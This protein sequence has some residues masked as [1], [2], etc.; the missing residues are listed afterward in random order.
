MRSTVLCLT[1]LVSL[2]GCE[3]SIDTLIGTPGGGGLTA[4]Q[5]SGNWSFTLTQAGPLSC[6]SG[7]L[8]NGQVLTARLDVL[9]DGTLAAT[10]FWQNPPTTAVRP[11][12]GSVNFGDGFTR[13][14]MLAS[15]GSAARMELVGTLTAAGSF[16]GTLSDPFS[17]APIVF[18]PCQFTVT[19]IKTG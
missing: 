1:L 15:T 17:G 4:A 16:T 2:A 19:G 3:T 13:F 8:V 5:A 6:P 11:L 9:S 14:F 12:T 10:S 7:S 18:G